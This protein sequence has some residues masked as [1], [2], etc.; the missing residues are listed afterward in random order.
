MTLSFQNKIVFPAPDASY[1]TQSA[2]GQV[3]YLPRN[4]M[5]Q[6]ETKL[7]QQ[8]RKKAGQSDETKSDVGSQRP[9]SPEAATDTANEAATENTSNQNESQQEEYLRKSQ[10]NLDL[11]ASQ[12][13]KNSG[14]VFQ[15]E[16]ELIQEESK[17]EQLDSARDGQ[18]VQDTEFMS[19][20]QTEKESQKA[21]LLKAQ[22]IE[23]QNRKTEEESKQII[24]ESKE[25]E[26]DEAQNDDDPAQ[27][28]E[29]QSE[30]GENYE[31]T[32]TTDQESKSKAS[33]KPLPQEG[34]Q[35][36]SHGA[37]T[38]SPR[39]RSGSVFGEK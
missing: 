5:K 15:E 1:T 30:I 20:V 12:Q 8:R 10:S 32:E 24:E 33:S 7:N 29:S 23:Q 2:F 37:K 3:V 27:V 21:A 34:L 39:S 17:Q 26:P 18:V 4:I 14:P 31:T 6:V 28:Q 38:V 16:G 9:V 19:I 22:L 36:K 35:T 11:K 25:S 13:K